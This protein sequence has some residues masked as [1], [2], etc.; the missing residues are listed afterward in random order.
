MFLLYNFN[1]NT[2]VNY[3]LNVKI[4]V[5]SVYILILENFYEDK[6]MANAVIEVT[7]K[8]FYENRVTQFL[9]ILQEL[10]VQG[11]LQ[12]NSWTTYLMQFHLSL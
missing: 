7:L 2:L 9:W 6:I 4:N 8:Q 10:G 5:Y 11:K 12:K 1:V 3:C